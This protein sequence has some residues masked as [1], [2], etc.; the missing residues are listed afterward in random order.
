MSTEIANVNPAEI[1]SAMPRAT[2]DEFRKEAMEIATSGNVNALTRRSQRDGKT[3]TVMHIGEQ[4][5]SDMIVGHVLTIVRVGHAS[6]PAV[7]NSG[8]PIFVTDTNGKQIV[9]EDGEPIQ[10]VSVFP[11]CHFKEAPG[12]WYNGGKLLQDNIDSWADET[13][14]DS[15]DFY[16]P[17][18]NA[19][20]EEIGGIRAYFEWKN[21][22]DGSGQ[23]YV[24]MILA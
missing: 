20:L 5:T 9:N 15:G 7:D 22:K 19:V 17:K 23:K 12:C 2:L 16:M 13:G 18:L 21:K 6:V 4:I 14:D 24:N 3:D 8:K 1:F 11:V 10:A